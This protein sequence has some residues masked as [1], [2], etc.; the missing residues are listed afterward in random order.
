VAAQH[1]RIGA[2]IVAIQG[3]APIMRLPKAKALPS[4]AQPRRRRSPNPPSINPAALIPG[5]HICLPTSRFPTVSVLCFA[6]G[7]APPTL[8]LAPDPEPTV[9]LD[10]KALFGT[11]PSSVGI[12]RVG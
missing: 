12:T 4:L 10:A 1:P 3:L 6:E 5:R 2:V 9:F 7:K 8:R 11:D